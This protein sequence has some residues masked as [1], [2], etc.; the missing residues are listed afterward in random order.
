[1]AAKWLIG[2]SMLFVLLTITSGIIEQTYLG[3][4]QA[5]TLWQLM[6]SFK[7]MQWSSFSSIIVAA[8]ALATALYKMLIFDYAFFTG[9]W[10][11]FRVLF[12]SVSVGIGVSFI[13]SVASV[14]PV[15]FPFT[16]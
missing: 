10:V 1:M 8:G 13:L 5:G 12:V 4:E 11:I 9:V 15:P 3:T 16:K 7:A 14:L 2:L 6:S